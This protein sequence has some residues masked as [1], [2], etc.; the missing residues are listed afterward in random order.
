MIDPPGLGRA[1]SRGGSSVGGA[2]P[3]TAEEDK[4][5]TIAKSV[6]VENPKIKDLQ[7]INKRLEDE[8]QEMR[9]AFTQKDNS[10]HFRKI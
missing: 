10:E 2:V 9:E 6:T 7:N 4:T 1:V 5:S 8:L 3:N